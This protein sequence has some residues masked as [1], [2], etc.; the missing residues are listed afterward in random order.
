MPMLHCY[1][2]LG[3]LAKHCAG[4]PHPADG[5]ARHRSRRRI[6]IASRARE[7]GP[8]PGICRNRRSAGRLQMHKAARRPRRCARSNWAIPRQC[9][10][11]VQ[12]RNRHA[13]SALTPRTRSGFR[14]RGAG[15]PSPLPPTEA[16]RRITPL[17]A[18]RAPY[19]AGR[20]FGVPHR[21]GSLRKPKPAARTIRGRLRRARIAYAQRTPARAQTRRRSSHS[22]S[23]SRARSAGSGSSKCP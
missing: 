16:V 3:P 22:R 7:K 10:S 17:R 19:R 21:L 13:A 1:I 9:C 20:G 11:T 15:R 5:G 6:C 18:S 23:E 12:F 14:S 4:T 8:R 2:D